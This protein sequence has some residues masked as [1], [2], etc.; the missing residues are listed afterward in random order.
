MVQWTGNIWFPVESRANWDLKSI[1]CLAW[2]CTLI[3][4]LPTVALSS[5]LVPKHRTEMT[6]PHV[7]FKSTFPMM[8]PFPPALLH[9][10]P[11]LDAFICVS[12]MLVVPDHIKELTIWHWCLAQL[13]LNC[14]LLQMLSH[15]Y[16]IRKMNYCLCFSACRGKTQNGLLLSSEPNWS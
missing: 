16:K 9:S 6:G 15:L 10:L 7:P 3:G 2:G 8:R 14:M 12:L 13:L 1:V 11:F 5:F 4:A